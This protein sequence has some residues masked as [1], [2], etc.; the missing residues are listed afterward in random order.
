MKHLGV[1]ILSIFNSIILLGQN[2]SG[3]I[4]NK[5]SKIYYE[6]FG[7][8][9]PLLIING[10]PGM[11]SKGFRY[12]A[13]LLSK[14]NKAIIYDQR[15]TGN[16]TVKLVNSETIT[17]DLMVDDI[18]KLRQYFQLK[19]W[20]ILGHSFGGILASY[21]ASKHPESIKSLILSAS[22]GLDLELLN[23]VGQNIAANLSEDETKRLQ[24]WTQKI[25]QGD[26]TYHARLER[27]KA[28]APAYVVDKSY[29]PTIAE[30]L[31]QGNQTINAFVFQDLRKINY[32]CTYTLKTFDKPVLIIQGKQDIIDKKTAEKAHE[33]FP[34]S[35]LVLLDDCGHYGWLDQKEKY[36]YEIHT[37]LEN[38]N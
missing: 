28:L 31:T 37:F 27:G 30:R 32:N 19:E 3:L 16:S 18:E 11:N 26:T 21:Y 13:Q 17:M 1:I 7:E 12:I 35:K 23:Y 4:E 34:N 24:E 5:S 33:T 9:E 20:T 15:G 8:G 22:G 29:V 36:L 2:S 14:S 38:H 6:T 25:N 10:G